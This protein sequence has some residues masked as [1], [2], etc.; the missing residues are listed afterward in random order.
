M[1]P[2]TQPNPETDQTAPA[3]FEHVNVDPMYVASAFAG[4]DF[5]SVKDTMFEPV[6][7]DTYVLEIIKLDPRHV[8]PKSGPNAFKL[9]PIVE[10]S[11]L[12]VDHPELSGRRLTKTFW[13]D[14]DPNNKDVKQLRKIANVTGVQPDPGQPMEEWAKQF[15]SLVPPARLVVPVDKISHKKNPGEFDNLIKF[16]RARRAE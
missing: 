4:I 6:P 8:T 12:I 15:E 1:E 16:F 14:N 13:V 5:T 10:G 9:M 2:M 11:F 7:T 3:G